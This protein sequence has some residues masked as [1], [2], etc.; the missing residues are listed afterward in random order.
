MVTG[1][2]QRVMIWGISRGTGLLLVTILLL[3]HQKG[4]GPS[5]QGIWTA[6][7]IPSAEKCHWATPG[8]DARVRYTFFMWAKEG[9]ERRD[10]R[11]KLVTWPK[12]WPLTPT[13]FSL[14]PQE[15]NH[16]E[17]YMQVDLGCNFFVDTV[18]WVSTHPLWAHRVQFP[19]SF[20]QQIFF[21]YLLQTRH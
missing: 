18:V 5:W 2:C 20:I 6:G 10:P 3:S 12:S 16:S 15:T 9:E 13:S 21:E 8:K 1:E 17:L 19:L 11:P 4:A 14:A 7:Q